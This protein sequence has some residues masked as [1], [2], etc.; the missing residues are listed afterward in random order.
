VS[1]FRFSTGG[2]CDH[3]CTQSQDHQRLFQVSSSWYYWH[4][5]P[6]RL[7]TLLGCCSS[8]ES[9]EGRHIRVSLPVLCD[10]TI[11]VVR[12][13]IVMEPNNTTVWENF[14][15]LSSQYFGH[16]DTEN[17][18]AQ[19]A[20][21]PPVPAST[22]Q[23]FN[24]PADCVQLPSLSPS[25][26]TDNTTYIDAQNCTSSVDNTGWTLFPWVVDSNASGAF[27]GCWSAE[28]ATI[29][30]PVT[31]P[32]YVPPSD[33]QVVQVPFELVACQNYVLI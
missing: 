7:A 8:V 28:G 13:T 26:S 29:L 3:A 22:L 18:G 25:S 24:R 2:V 12:Q 33:E 17:L 21:F 11:R 15:G 6:L 4:Y 27:P 23:Y 30:T 19:F 5:T 9:Y 10:S 16:F 32:A 20:Y 14:A 1:W 31:S